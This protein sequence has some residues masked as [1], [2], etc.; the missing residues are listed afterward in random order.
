MR[1]VYG[2]I[3]ARSGK[4]IETV[5]TSDGLQVMCGRPEGPD[6]NA[7]GTFFLEK[8]QKD[9]RYEIF[10]WRGDYLPPSAKL[11]NESGS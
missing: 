8:N 6:M 10:D 3:T 9:D 1:Q 11:T 2:Q 5:H 7:T 4:T